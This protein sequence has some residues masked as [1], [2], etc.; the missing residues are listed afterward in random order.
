MKDEILKKINENDTISFDIFDTLLLRNIYRPTDIFRILSKI[1][2]EKYNINDFYDIR[3]TSESESRS[4]KN[5]MECHF[6]EIYKT[7]ES[8]IKDKKVAKKLKEEELYLE[9][10]FL[11]VNPF[12]KEIYDY[13]LTKN[14]KVFLISDMYLDEKFIQGILKKCGYKDYVLYLSNVYKKNK[15]DTSL[16]EAV[17][18]KEKIKKSNWLHIGDNRHSDYD[19][20][21]QFGINAYHYKGVYSYVNI[22]KYSIFE[23]IML[24]IQNNYL[25]NGLNINYWEGFGI[26]NISPIYFG[27]TKWLY[28]LTK[29]LDNLFFIARDGY[30][31]DKIYSFFNKDKKV[32]TDYLYCSRKS[33]VIPSLYKMQTEKMVNILSLMYNP[34]IKYTLKDFLL[35][36]E[37]NLEEI[38][39]EIIKDFGFESLD[40][41]VTVDNYYDAK[42][43]L[44]IYSENIKKNLRGKYDLAVE[45]LKQEGVDDYTL[46][47]IMDIGW[48][49]SI[50]SSIKRLL[51]KEVNGYYFGTVDEK[52]EDG[53]STM[54]G[55]YF[56]LSHDFQNKQTIL[57]NV[58]MYELIFSAPHGTT[59]GYEKKNDRIVPILKSNKEYNDIVEKFQNSAMQIIKE[60][61]KYIEYFDY[62]SKDFCLYSYR[63]FIKDRKY[64]DVKKFSELSNDYILGSDKK[65]SYVNITNMRTI[66]D[67]QKFIEEARKSLWSNTFMIDD[68]S[69]GEHQ[70]LSYKNILFTNLHNLNPFSNVK[71]YLDYGKGFNEINTL[72]IPL[73]KEG[74]RYSF[75][76]KFNSMYKTIYNIRIDPIEG[77]KIIM[78]N[79]VIYSDIGGVIASIPHKNYILGRLKKCIYIS[80]KD[81]KIIINHT[82]NLKYIKFM[83]NIE[84]I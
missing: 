3:V 21:I 46:I 22:N 20:P 58:M 35:K 57:D 84:I 75:K 53:F 10:K 28:D 48:A 69:F 41:F 82:E 8:K 33:F 29:N 62:L 16:F 78:R 42:K 14:K 67:N 30:I 60:Y 19:I 76:F 17:L 66:K 56:D 55:Y 49:G 47:N 73:E 24:G 15:G 54:F 34:N 31:I 51:N 27:F 13:C 5:N 7:I 70:Y 26:K 43:L 79:L 52:Q 4:E 74:N 32:H 50:Q 38:D 45:Y 25:Y 23:S 44:V 37:I 2:L 40:T 68:K 71:I 72:F 12:M 64:E 81:P 9:E 6:D 61:L 59:I 18:N 1:A 77:T 11:V 39:T 80:S 83:A 65:F 63:N 36:C